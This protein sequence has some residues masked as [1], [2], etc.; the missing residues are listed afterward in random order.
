MGCNAMSLGRV[1]CLLFLPR[2]RRVVG[3]LGGGGGAGRTHTRRISLPAPQGFE[4]PPPCLLLGRQR[5]PR[6]MPGVPALPRL[7]STCPHIGGIWWVPWPSLP[8]GA[9][10]TCG[11][12]PPEP[13][14]RVGWPAQP[15]AAPARVLGLT[16]QKLTSPVRVQDPGRQGASGPPAATL[17]S[18]WCQF[19]DRACLST[20]GRGRPGASPQPRLRGPSVV[21][22][23]D[24]E[25]QGVVFRR[26]AA[27]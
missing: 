21:S 23:A 26:P 14:R 16:H 27:P 18:V 12:R 5:A 24:L 10:P 11:W 17:A 13:G 7:C 15:C 6:A 2:G 3:R 8:G 4:R 1:G 22:E 25:Q 19:G 9:T 20:A